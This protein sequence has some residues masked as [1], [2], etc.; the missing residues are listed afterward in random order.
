MVGLDNSARQLEHAR[1]RMAAAGVDFPLVH[2]AAEAVPLPDASFDVVFCDHGAMTFADPLL[3][4]P[5]V[6]R[7]LRPGGLLAFS[8]LHAVR[9]GSAPTRRTRSRSGSCCDY[10]GI[11]RFDD[12]DGSV[13]F[14]LPYGEWIRLFR[15]HGFTRRGPDRGPAARGRRVDLPDAGGDG[16]GAALADGGDL[17]GAQ[18]ELSEH[19]KRNQAAWE[20]EAPAYEE[21]GRRNWA[22]EREPG[23]GIWRVPESELQRASGRGRQGR[24]R[25]RLRHR[26]LVGVARADGRAAGRRRHHRRPA[27]ER[28]DVHGRVRA[29]VPA[30]SRRPPRTCRFRTRASTSRSRSTAP[31]SGATRTLWVAEAA[32]LLRPGGELIFLVN[33][34]CYAM[35]H[36]GPAEGTS[37]SSCATT[38]ACAASSG[39]T[40]T[41]S[42][43]TSATASGSDSSARTAL[44]SRT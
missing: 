34:T 7:V 19:A 31:R 43:S 24:G 30:R 18:V 21:A 27:G 1:E 42:T 39:R 26:L 32:R 8:P 4:V 44:R 25:A 35:P 9:A 22:G 15:A 20:L 40:T 10:F 3:V 12:T 37:S 2:A 28:A 16:L 29:R 41:A 38:S 14:Q 36:R 11:H 33:G 6:A 13:L 23:W 17:E 5:E